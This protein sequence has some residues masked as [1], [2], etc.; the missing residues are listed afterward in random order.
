M[1]PLLYFV[2]MALVVVIA[3]LLLAIDGKS[4]MVDEEPT[5][6]TRGDDR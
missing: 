4:D 2:G 1:D 3:W 6:N 5:L